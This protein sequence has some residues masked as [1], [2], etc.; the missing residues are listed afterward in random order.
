MDAINDIGFLHEFFIAEE[1]AD[2]DY[3]NQRAGDDHEDDMS[4]EEDCWPLEYDD[5]LF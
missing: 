1:E 2:E 4:D 5:N 3:W